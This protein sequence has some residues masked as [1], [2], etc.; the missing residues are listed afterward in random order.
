MIR[1]NIVQM[2]RTMSALERQP[3]REARESK[4]HAT[5][6]GSVH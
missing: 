4:R 6:A 5:H 3:N 2:W 1:A